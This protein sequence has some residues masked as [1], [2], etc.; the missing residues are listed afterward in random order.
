MPKLPLISRLALI[1][2]L[3]VLAPAAALAHAGMATTLDTKLIDAQ[4]KAQGT[5]RLKADGAVTRVSVHAKGLTPGS[6]GMHLHAV[7]LCET[8]GFTTAGGHWNP[9]HKQHGTANPMGPHKGDLPAFVADAK[10]VGKAD[11]TVPAPLTDIVDADGAAL[12]IHA[13]AD[14]NMTDPS[15]NSGARALCAAFKPIAGADHTMQH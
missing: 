7:G 10:G 11:F 13:G 4:G 12:V 6:H 1:P 9:D 15:G 5:V 8:P 3:A 14:D 2:A